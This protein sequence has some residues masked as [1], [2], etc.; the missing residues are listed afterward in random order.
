MTAFVNYSWNFGEC[1][2]FFS[3]AI[4]PFSTHL[5]PLKVD[6]FTFYQNFF[7]VAI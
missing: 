2:H 6:T 7:C 5:L 3:I 4:A 1:V